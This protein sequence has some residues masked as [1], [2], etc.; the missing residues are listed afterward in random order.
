M[1]TL[2]SE[3]IKRTNRIICNLIVANMKAGFDYQGAKDRAYNRMQKE[4]PKVLAAWLT[5]HKG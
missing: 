5:Y 1:T 2:N 4:A 3:E